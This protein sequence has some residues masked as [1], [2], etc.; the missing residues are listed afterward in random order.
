MRCTERTQKEFI[1]T[2]RQFKRLQDLGYVAIPAILSQTLGPN[3]RHI[4]FVSP[5][6]SRKRR[7]RVHYYETS[8]KPDDLYR[9]AGEP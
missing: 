7:A 4:Y 3:W 1:L 5:D 2:P 6:G 9:L 8:L